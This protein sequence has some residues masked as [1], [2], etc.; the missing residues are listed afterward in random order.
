MK[1]LLIAFF[2]IVHSPNALSWTGRGYKQ[3]LQK[4]EY[5]GSKE[6]QAVLKKIGDSLLLEMGQN[7]QV[8][9]LSIAGRA[10]TTLRR[11][12]IGSQYVTFDVIVNG[13]KHETV[14]LRVNRHSNIFYTKVDMKKPI[15]SSNAK[16]ISLVLA[17]NTELEIYNVALAD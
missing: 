16:N 7:N 8:K 14:T 6:P 15:D 9:T 17:Q 13:E 10:L 4:Q 11:G 3:H 12:L 1:S 5:L 2:L